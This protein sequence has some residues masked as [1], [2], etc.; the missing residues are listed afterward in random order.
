MINLHV[1]KLILASFDLDVDVDG[2]S[3]LESIKS[4]QCDGAR[5]IPLDGVTCDLCSSLAAGVSFIGL[6]C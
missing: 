6:C 5:F 3:A 4:S 2:V 1:S